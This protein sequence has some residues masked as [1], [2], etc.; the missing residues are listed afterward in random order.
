MVQVDLNS[1][2]G[3]EIT[4]RVDIW[5]LGCVLYTLAFYQHPFQDNA[6]AMAISNAKY[7][8]P[9]DHPKAK[10]DKLCSLINWLLSADPSVRPSAAQLSD[11]LRNLQQLPF[12]KL[13]ESMPEA[14]RERINKQQELFKAGKETGDVTV[15]VL[16]RNSAPAGD[17]RRAPVQ[18]AREDA[19]ERQRAA[20]LTSETSRASAS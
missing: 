17:R 2:K 4:E 16:R 14:V 12:A 1:R 5:M 19:E 3:Y 11:I 15:D 13:L 6:T 18:R 7:F 8:I 10:S 20:T 9:K